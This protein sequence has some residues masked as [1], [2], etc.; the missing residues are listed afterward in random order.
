MSTIATMCAHFYT[1]VT[2]CAQYKTICAHLAIF[3]TM[4]AHS[5]IFSAGWYSR[6][7]GVVYVITGFF[8]PIGRIFP[9]S[10]NRHFSALYN[11]YNARA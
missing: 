5:R 8:P 4:H 2:I 6:I 3:E 1:Y 10:P 7:A 11:G 9:W